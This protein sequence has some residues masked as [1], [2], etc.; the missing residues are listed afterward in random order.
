MKGT[1][2][3]VFASAVGLLT[4][5]AP[6]RADIIYNTNLLGSMETPPNASTATG[7]FSLDYNPA[8]TTSVTYTLTFSGLS[9]DATMAHV[10]FGPAG[11]SGAV[12][13]TL[14]DFG[15][16]PSQTV[17]SG[18]YSG[19]LSSANFQPDTVDGVDT[20]ANFLTDLQDGLIYV[21]V[22]STNYPNGEIRGQLSSVPEPG[23]LGL[24]ASA[25]TLVGFGAYRRRKTS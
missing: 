19:T 7:T 3:L 1:L 6:A 17:T 15:L 10:H 5:A 23:S 4:Y 13:F 18:T 12:L 2:A 16:P 24:L 9:S 22:H 8:N 25:F 20:F 21:N 11:E 14:F